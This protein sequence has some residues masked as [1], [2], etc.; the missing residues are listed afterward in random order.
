MN[1]IFKVR[2]KNGEYAIK[3]IPITNENKLDEERAI[4]SYLK[5]I[6][7]PN[8]MKY[9]NDFYIDNYHF[10][11]FENYDISLHDFILDNSNHPINRKM[12]LQISL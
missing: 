7:Y 2:D 11:L 8:I 4:A 5:S 9:V 3:V 6:D 12:F 1:D 10:I